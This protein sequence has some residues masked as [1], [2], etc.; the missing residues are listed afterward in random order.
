MNDI[1][2]F[3][4]PFALN[5]IVSYIQYYDT[6]EAMEPWQAWMWVGIMAIGQLSLSFVAQYYFLMVFRIAMKTRAAIVT[7][8]YKKA[9]KLANTSRQDSTTG[10]IVNHMSIDAQRLMDLIP[11]LH[12]LW[13]GPL[14]IIRTHALLP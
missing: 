6:K 14:Q 9:F 12:Q 7:V 11:Y 10:E 3:V 2:T 13:S 5:R 8:I 4:G 1:L